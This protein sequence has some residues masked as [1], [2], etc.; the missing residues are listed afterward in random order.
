MTDQDKLIEIM[1]QNIAEKE[2]YIYDLL[3]D[4]IRL[5]AELVKRAHT[6]Q[7]GRT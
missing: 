1:R 3:R 6:N 4:N 5:Q 7:E 2:K